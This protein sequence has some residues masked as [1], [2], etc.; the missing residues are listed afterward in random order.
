MNTKFIKVLLSS[1]VVAASFAAVPAFAITPPIGAEIFCIRYAQH[2]RADSTEQV[3]FSEGLLQTLDRVNRNVNRSMRYV[4]DRS[5][6]DDWRV[7][8]SSG[9]C[10]DYALTKR[11]QLISKGV[12]AGALRVAATHTRRGEPHAV[13]IVKTDKGDYVL[14]NRV[15]DVKTRASAGYRITM[16]ASSDPRVWV[17][18]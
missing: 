15:A 14:D 18:G 16:M 2:C 5:V 13:L 7:G 6:V 10:E 9:D 3:A 8:G 4:P 17:R 11:A 1:A 12:P